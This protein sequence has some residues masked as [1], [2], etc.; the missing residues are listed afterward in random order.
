MSVCERVFRVGELQKL[1][2]EKTFQEA[3]VLIRSQ[4][5]TH[6]HPYP[7]IDYESLRVSSTAIA[8][9]SKK[10]PRHCTRNER[11]SAH[12][13]RISIDSTNTQAATSPVWR[14]TEHASQKHERNRRR[15]IQAKRGN[16]GS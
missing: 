10:C 12:V 7:H 4:H 8:C 13:E 16:T 14:L 2:G 6:H 15:F 3:A 1:A 9:F 11:H 5:L